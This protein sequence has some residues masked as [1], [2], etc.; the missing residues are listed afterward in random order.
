MRSWLWS[1][2]G[3]AL[4]VAYWT[5]ISGVATT[6]RWD[7]AALLSVVLFVSPR[8]TMT[9]THK[10]GLA[11][12]GWLAITLL[13]SAGAGRLDGVNELFQLMLIAIAFSV[14]AIDCDA[15]A[16]LVG[17]AVGIGLNSAV[18]IAQWYGWRLGDEIIDVPS[19]LFFNP[20]RMGA[21]AAMVI[22]GLLFGNRRAWLI[23][24]C[25]PALILSHSIAAGLAV[26]AAV[27]VLP[28]RGS[29]S[30]WTVRGVMVVV[31]GAAV[32]CKY[33]VAAT[34]ER[35][36]IW[37]ATINQL[38]W[39]GH[40]LGSYREGIFAHASVYDVLKYG[41]RPEHPHNEWLW[42]AYEGGVVVVCL[43]VAFAVWTWRAAIDSPYRGVLAAVFVLGLVAMPLHDP[44]TA[45]LA[46]LL[47]GHCVGGHARD[48][49]RAVERR[50]AVLARMVAAAREGKCAP[51]AAGA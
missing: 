25:L 29:R 49:E 14:A 15:D 33:G 13:W 45:I 3:L 11:L 30:G 51:V 36:L 27:F 17:A 47:A 32:A 19:G 10:I 31:A 39:L 8:G 50:A 23:P 34:D 9:R 35:L 1:A 22:A 24:L 7:V 18:A 5:G 43:A 44:A 26:C 4:M 38:D 48:G 46:A 21:A 28:E 42:L 2:F 41:T 37:S 6:P 20:A 16:L 40:G 12:I